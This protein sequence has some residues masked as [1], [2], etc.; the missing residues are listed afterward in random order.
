MHQFCQTFISVTGLKSRSNQVLK[1]EVIL[2]ELTNKVYQLL[3]CGFNEFW[4]KKFKIKCSRL[5]S[6]IYTI[7]AL[8]CGS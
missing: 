6:V 8:Y 4:R 7:F 2:T 1:L 5:L 3:Y